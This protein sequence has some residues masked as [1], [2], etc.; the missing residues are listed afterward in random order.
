MY[1]LGNRNNSNSPKEAEKMINPA[2]NCRHK[3]PT[4]P[5]HRCPSW[6]NRIY[7]L[8]QSSVFS[9]GSAHSSFRVHH[10]HH[11]LHLMQPLQML[12]ATA[13]KNKNNAQQ[14]TTLTNVD[15]S[16]QSHS[17]NRQPTHTFPGAIS[18]LECSFQPEGCTPVF[19]CCEGIA[20]QVRNTPLSDLSSDNSDDEHQDCSPEKGH[21]RLY[22][23]SPMTQHADAADD[24]DGPAGDYD[25]PPDDIDSIQNQF[26]KCS[27]DQTKINRPM[28]LSNRISM[29]NCSPLPCPML[30]RQGS[31]SNNS[32]A[33]AGS[34]GRDSVMSQAKFADEVELSEQKCGFLLCC[35][36]KSWKQR[37]FVLRDGQLTYFRT[38]SDAH[39]ASKTVGRLELGAHSQ[40]TRLQNSNTFQIT[41]QP[42]GKPISLTADSMLT[43][44]EWIRVIIQM[45]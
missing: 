6:E 36:Q 24:D 37:Y 38:Q 10:D 39:K 30:L 16:V 12:L 5:L 13:K 7:S 34:S 35:K 17:G 41:S 1:A 27:L 18:G 32:T 33:T 44:E 22:K 45:I 8:A 28:L 11:P 31:R 25:L 9:A 26:Q 2:T 42:N 14:S 29:R 23:K 40:V 20:S 43:M 19:V 21:P 4:P 3:P 15:H